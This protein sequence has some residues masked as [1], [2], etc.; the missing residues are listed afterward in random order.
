MTKRLQ[1]MI[2]EIYAEVYDL[3]CQIKSL[4]K[5]EGTTEKDKGIKMEEDECKAISER[6]CK[7]QQSAN[8]KERELTWLE[9][10]LEKVDTHVR[11]AIEAKEKWKL[12]VLRILSWEAKEM[13][14]R[15]QEYFVPSTSMHPKPIRHKWRAG[16]VKNVKKMRTARRSK[17]SRDSREVKRGQTTTPRHFRPNSLTG[18]FM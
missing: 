17:T 16:K 5:E 18:Y 9:R 14:M 13:E 1:E 15:I 7:L 3:S 6:I 8:I 12:R 4:K 11:L 10:V 2:S